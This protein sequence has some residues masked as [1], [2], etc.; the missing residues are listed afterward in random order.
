M[1]S[2]HP[3]DSHQHGTHQ[4]GSDQHDRDQHD[5][6]QHGSPHRHDAVGDADVAALI[7]L[8]DLDAEVT[9]AYLS[10]VVAWVHEI[11]G[12]RP[13]RRI[14]DLGSGTGTGALALLRRFEPANVVAVDMSSPMLDRLLEKAGDLADRIHTVR[15]DLDDAWPAVD[16]VDLVWASNSLH[17]MAEPARTLADVFATIRPGGLLVVAELDSFPRF[18][19]DD[20]GLGRPGLEARCHAAMDQ[21]RANDLPHFG[22]DWGSS[23][24]AAGFAI[25][26][27][28]TFAID[29]T[30]PLPAATGR[31]AQAS[32]RRMRSGLDRSSLDRSGADR[33]GADLSDLDGRMSAD[34]LATLDSLIDSDGPQSV[35]RR[36]DLSVHTARTVWVARRP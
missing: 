31:Y 29:L 10:D 24:T 7:E 23:L 4:H 8:L 13:I 2:H 36:D 25:E 22:S 15:A 16:P 14:L 30:R 5:R 32:L 21:L 34:D 33:S 17:H 9:Q 26:A 27:E 18:L 19:P 12:D 6:D 20:L 3:H 28:R 1:D 11:V 35:L